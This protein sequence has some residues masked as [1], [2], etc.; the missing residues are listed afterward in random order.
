MYLVRYYGRAANTPAKLIFH[1]GV[2]RVVDRKDDDLGWL[3]LPYA[4]HAP[5]VLAGISMALGDL[6][7]TRELGLGRF[8]GPKEYF[9]GP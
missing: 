4:D 8:N 1:A 5:D 7:H 2:R 9:R 3:C 6:H